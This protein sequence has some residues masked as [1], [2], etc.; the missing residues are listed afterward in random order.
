VLMVTPE[1]PRLAAERQAKL[2]ALGPR[3]SRWRLFARRRWES[4]RASILAMD[5]S[6]VAA[7]LQGIYTTAH[8]EEMASRPSPL[9][10]MFKQPYMPHEV[11]R[12]AKP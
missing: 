12:K 4:A 7:M 11:V 6:E 5:V 9:A 1:N 8:V 3:P 10:A 2:K